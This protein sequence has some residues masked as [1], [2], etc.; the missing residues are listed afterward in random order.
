MQ[1]WRKRLQL[2]RGGWLL[3]LAATV[4]IVP[5]V[6][7]WLG[8]IYTGSQIWPGLVGNSS[9][10]LVAFVLA[11]EWERQRS[12]RE[13][14]AARRQRREALEQESERAL[15]QRRSEVAGRLRSVHAELV[16][17]ERT[18]EETLYALARQEPVVISP[19]AE[20]PGRHLM[21][22]SHSSWPTQS[23]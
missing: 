6:V 11:L 18:V 7:L 17:G 12:T 16:A 10:S 9:G 19:F 15:Q 5:P 8:G 21:R 22:G 23:S 14:D 4:L 20:E 13:R 3:V 2:W 1:T